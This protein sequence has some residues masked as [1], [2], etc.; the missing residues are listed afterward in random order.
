[1]SNWEVENPAHALASFYGNRWLSIGRH[2]EDENNTKFYRINMKIDA[3]GLTCE[4]T[5]NLFDELD[6]I[7]IY[8]CRDDW[9]HE[10][11]GKLKLKCIETDDE[12]DYYHVFT[13]KGTVAEEIYDEI[14]EV[15][16]KFSGKIKVVE[17]V[18]EK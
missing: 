9:E 12:D 5:S 16:N 13:L 4:E 7:T 3:H 11:T 6:D 15:L 17:K 14:W 18:A 8:R 10:Y 1:M 2:Y